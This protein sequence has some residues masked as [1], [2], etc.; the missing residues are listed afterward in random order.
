M[1]VDISIPLERKPFPEKYEYDNFTYSEKMKEAIRQM[2]RDMWSKKSDVPLTDE[3]VEK[4]LLI[5]Q[6]FER[7]TLA[8]EEEAKRRGL[9]PDNYIPAKKVISG[10]LEH[11]IAQYN[12]EEHIIRLSLLQILDLPRQMKEEI[13]SDNLAHPMVDK[14]RKEELKLE[15]ELGDYAFLCGAHE[16]RH[17]LE[18]EY[19]L[20]QT[21]L[22]D[23]YTPEEYLDQPHEYRALGWMAFF[24]KRHQMSEK[25][26]NF[27]MGH[28]KNTIAYRQ[29]KKQAA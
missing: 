19:L 16:M 4:A 5:A 27:F 3:Q 12:S 22:E 11:V 14:E 18:Q 15:I 13:A 7:G 23:G 6:E 2:I 29:Q 9:I 17:S 25:V 20:Q 8:M 10:W 1:S 28:L 21:A 24:A 26:V